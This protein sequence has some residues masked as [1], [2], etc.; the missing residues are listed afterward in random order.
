MP[1]TQ[2]MIDKLSDLLYQRGVDHETLTV[3]TDRNG[4]NITTVTT[5]HRRSRQYTVVTFFRLRGRPVMMY[6][7]KGG[8]QQLRRFSSCG[9]GTHFWESA[10]NYAKLHF[11]LIRDIC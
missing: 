9:G 11:E 5:I 8:K 7:V 6:T 1:S 2:P 10:L 3:S 4:N